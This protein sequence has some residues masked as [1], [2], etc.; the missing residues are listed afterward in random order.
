ML[1]NGNPLQCSCLENSMDRGTWW[2]TVHG[3]QRVRH[4]WTEQLTPT[5]THTCTHTHIHKVLYGLPWW[6]W[7][8]NMP[9]VWKMKET[10][11]WS[12]GQEDPGIKPMNHMD[13]GAWRVIVQRAAKSGTRQRTKHS[14][15]HTQ[16]AA[17]LLDSLFTVKDVLLKML[18]CSR[19]VMSDS[20]Q[21]HGL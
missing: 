10:C 15:L 21:S 2:A 20:L 8:K 19:L 12:L 9:A 7:V 13:G 14:H 6:H 3:S 18:L 5:H 4:D 1:L 11:V 16:S 17:Y